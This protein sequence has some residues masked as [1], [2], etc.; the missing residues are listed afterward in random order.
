MAI[1]NRKLSKDFYRRSD[2]V[3]IARDLL[4]QI[5]VTRINGTPTAGYI[6]ETEA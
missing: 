1:V 6:T 4:G 3:G 2:V 5:L